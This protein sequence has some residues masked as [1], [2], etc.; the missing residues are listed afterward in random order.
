VTD[1]YALLDA[2]ASPVELGAVRAV[3]VAD[4]AWIQRVTARPVPSPE[5][6]TTHD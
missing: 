1:P 6:T 4:R 3:A 2:Y 5:E